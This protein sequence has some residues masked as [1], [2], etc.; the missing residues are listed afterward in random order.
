MFT[1]SILLAQASASRAAAAAVSSSSADSPSPLSLASTATRPPLSAHSAVYGP[2]DEEDPFVER[3][4]QEDWSHWDAIRVGGGSAGLIFRCETV[5]LIA[6]ELRD[7]LNEDASSWISFGYWIESRLQA[8]K[9]NSPDQHAGMM[10][11][12]FNTLRYPRPT[13]SQH[14]N[15]NKEKP[16][17]FKFDRP[18]RNK[19]PAEVNVNVNDMDISETFPQC[20]EPLV[21]PAASSPVASSTGKTAHH[22]GLSPAPHCLKEGFLFSPCPLLKETE[23]S[24]GLLAKAQ[25]LT[26]QNTTRARRARS[27]SFSKP[28]SPKVRIITTEVGMSCSQAC[29][30]LT[31]DPSFV[32][33]RLSYWLGLSTPVAPYGYESDPTAFWYLNNCAMMQRLFGACECRYVPRISAPFMLMET[34]TTKSSSSSDNYSNKVC[35]LQ[36]HNLWP[37][38]GIDLDGWNTAIHK[39]GHRACACVPRPGYDQSQF[40]KLN[41]VE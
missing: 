34:T 16:L 17:S 41:N 13:D 35:M 6:Q 28:S 8:W 25:Q 29:D 39:K 38:T 15:D 5:K 24:R 26:V 14:K 30:S 10:T 27:H 23:E 20:F 11:Y 3:N 4:L 12:A 40:E 2:E 37:S 22:T 9:K 33:S 18:N 19:A 1:Y 32:P 7:A 21:W 31:E 36:S